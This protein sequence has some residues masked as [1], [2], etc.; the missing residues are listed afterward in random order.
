MQIPLK[1]S[2]EKI[3]GR[4][5]RKI[6]VLLCKLSGINDDLHV[7][8]S[9]IS[10]SDVSMKAV[11]SKRFQICK[12]NIGAY[13]YVATNSL[14]SYAD[15]G[16]FCSVGPNF[17]CG[18]GIHPVDKLSTAPMF[19][20]TL[21]QNGMTLSHVDKVEERKLIKIGNDVFIGANVTVLD[22][23]TIGDGAVIG[24]CALVNK[25]VPPYAVVGGCP[26]RIIKYRMSESQIKDLLDIRWWDFPEEQL[27][28]VEKY[29][30]DIDGFIS[31]Y[32]KKDQDK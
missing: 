9:G 31:K 11:L 18:W 24:A 6:A 4:I 32:R 23:V 15:I 16:K 20:S 2:K 7:I 21:K 25:D 27:K 13:T 14:I 22:G 3:F 1:H 10:D 17:L 12:S 28:D 19:Y 29:F 30:D 8:Q 5:L 26:A